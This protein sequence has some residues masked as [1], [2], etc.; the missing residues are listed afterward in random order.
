VWHHTAAAVA[1]AVAALA[2]AVERLD[3]EQTRV[4]GLEDI[5][6]QLE[7]RLE[8]LSQLALSAPSTGAQS[9][10]NRISDRVGLKTHVLQVSPSGLWYVYGAEFV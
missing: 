3:N 10:R 7:A 4:Q 8:E 2:V 6:S 9:L 1:A 5:V